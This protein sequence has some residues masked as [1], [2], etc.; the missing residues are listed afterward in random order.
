MRVSVVIP[1][2]DAQD[3][4]GPLLE[5]LLAQD[6]QAASGSDGAVGDDGTRDL[7]EL[8]LGVDSPCNSAEPASD[9]GAAC[10]LAEPESGAG[11]PCDL[12]QPGLGAGAACDLAESETGTA[13]S[14]EPSEPETGDA[15][16][17]EPAESAS[18]PDSSAGSAELASGAGELP[19]RGWDLDILVVDS[20]SQDATADIVRGYEAHYPGRVRLMQIAREDFD[21]GG[22]RDLALRQT[23]GEYM[24]FLSQ[25]ALPANGQLVENLLAGFS[26]PSVAAVCGR[27][28][29]RLDAPLYERLTREFNYPATA[30]VWGERD[31]ARCGVKAYFFSDT[32][33][34]YRR[35]AYLAVG[36]FDAPVE[37]NEDML[38]AAK[39][40][41]AGYELAYEPA[42][43]VIHSHDHTLR[44][45]F[46][47]HEG[48]GFVMWRYRERLQGADVISEGRRLVRFVLGALLKQGRIDQMC[49]FLAHVCARYAGNRAGIRRAR[50]EGR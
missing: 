47:R 35:E 3:Y 33:A 32:C 46:E 12:A 8:G 20:S 13:S 34:A 45:E 23:A 31:I 29:A 4:I 11:F 40:F 18:E 9:A 37:A 5:S 22:T 42:A 43:A 28:V 1:T 38:M 50:R 21:H 36:G 26:K 17:C 24:A 49:V 19:P 6:G 15:S 14:G 2:L 25:D 16:S 10:S 48:E 44:Q 27:H 41:H 7:A 30:S 39:L